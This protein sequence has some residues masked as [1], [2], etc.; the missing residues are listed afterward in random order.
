M[1]IHNDLRNYAGLR[2]VLLPCVAGGGSASQLQ[3]QAAV[4][5]VC[6]AAVHALGWYT[7]GQLS[8]DIA[9]AT[10]GNISM[11]AVYWLSAFYENLARCQHTWNAVV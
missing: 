3:L 1:V 7:R 8:C 10:D 2:T 11:L 5:P 4:R 9:M 6:T